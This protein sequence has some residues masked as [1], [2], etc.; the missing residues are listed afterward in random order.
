MISLNLL[1][2][3]LLCLI[4]FRKMDVVEWSAKLRR[5]PDSKDKRL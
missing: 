5:I 1:G 4:V 2:M 3:G